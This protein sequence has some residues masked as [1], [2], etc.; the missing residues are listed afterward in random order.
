MSLV[1]KPNRRNSSS[2]HVL[3]V[4]DSVPFREYIVSTLATQ[5]GLEVVAEVS[6]GLEAVQKAQELKPDLIL[7]DIGLPSISGIEAARRIRT[8]V[9]ESKVIFL[10]Q[11]SSADVI[12]TALGTG[13]SA[14]VL[15]SNA[16]TLLLETVRTTLAQN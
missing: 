1:H 14:Y 8:L 7:M 13:A 10:S 15:K 11:E 9:P 12:Q 6:D 3:V 4:E 5:H 16:E 2:I